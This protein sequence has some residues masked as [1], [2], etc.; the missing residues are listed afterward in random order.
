MD[1][2]KKRVYYGW[3]VVGA[4]FILAFSINGL[5]FSFGLY[6]KPLIEEFGW[7]RGQVSLAA[8]IGIVCFSMSS[9]LSG[10][11]TDRYGPRIVCSIG[12]LVMGIGVMLTAFIGELWQLYL[13]YGLLFGLGGGTQEKPPSSTVV[14]FFTRKRGMALGLATAGIGAGTLVMAPII[15]FFISSS[16]WRQ[17]CLISGLVP[18]IIGIPISVIFMRRSPEDIGLLPDGG[19]SSKIESSRAEYSLKEALMSPQFRVILAMYVCMSTGLLGVMYHLPAYATDVGI[20]AMWTATAVGLV[21]GFS[22]AGRI[23]AGIISDILSRRITLI[24]IFSIQIVAMISLIWVKTGTALTFWVFVFGFCYGA[25]IVTTWG[26]V[27]D[28]FGRKAVAGILGAVAL[29]AGIGGFLGPWAAGYIYD[30][31]MSYVKAFLLFAGTFLLADIFA[32]LLR[33]TRE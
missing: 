31:T 28:V 33:P 12:A 30:A 1:K 27:A 13:T 22:I 32:F 14:R 26:L 16:G 24:I 3:W 5:Y 23:I 20:P 4:S 25:M 11:L 29:G 9:L 10:I 17:A 6:Q 21:G 15:Q 18:I 19:K 7:V 8:T 2:L